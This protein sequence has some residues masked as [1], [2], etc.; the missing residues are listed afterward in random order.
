MNIDAIN[1]DNCTALH[2]T[3]MGFRASGAG[4]HNA[5]GKPSNG[6]DTLRLTG[7]WNDLPAF[8]HA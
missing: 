3:S 6:E 1:T 2:A 8:R 4:A 5:A 7:A